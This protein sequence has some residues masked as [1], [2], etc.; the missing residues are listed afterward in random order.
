M[1]NF[2]SCGANFSLATGIYTGITV[3]EEQRK[4]LE[5]K[6]SQLILSQN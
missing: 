1:I 4:A 3:M 2:I 6:I 5:D